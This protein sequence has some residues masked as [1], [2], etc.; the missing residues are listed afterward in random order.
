MSSRRLRES[1]LDLGHR[2]KGFRAL[3]GLSQG[4]AGKGLQRWAQRTPLA[5]RAG[6]FVLARVD[7]NFA[8]KRKHQ[9]G[10]EQGATEIRP[11]AAGRLLVPRLGEERLEAEVDGV[12]EVI[13]PEL[14]PNTDTVVSA[15]PS[16]SGPGIA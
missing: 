15:K 6:T 2:A 5:I 3:P 7:N 4:Q 14:V 13:N 1:K 16:S 12:Q 9:A 8:L 11:C 10:A